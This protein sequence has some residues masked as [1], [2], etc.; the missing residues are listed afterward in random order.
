[1]NIQGGWAAGQM[2]GSGK[3]VFMLGDY[4]AKYEG[5]WVQGTQVGGKVKWFLYAELKCQFTYC[6]IMNVC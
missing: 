5:S 2:E 4:Q 6:Y 3:M 1:M